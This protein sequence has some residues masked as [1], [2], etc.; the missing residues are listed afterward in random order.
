MLLWGSPYIFGGYANH[1][2]P[3]TRVVDRLTSTFVFKRPIGQQEKQSAYITAT[4]K[5]ELGARD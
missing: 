1:S 2:R 4:T 5:S 3:G